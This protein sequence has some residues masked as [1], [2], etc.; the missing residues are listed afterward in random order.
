MSEL[1]KN[2]DYSI[3]YPT[4]YTEFLVNNDSD[5]IYDNFRS[6]DNNVFCE[7]S[8]YVKDFINKYGILLRYNYIKAKNFD[9]NFNLNFKYT[10]DI[11]NEHNEKLNVFESKYSEDNFIS[12]IRIYKDQYEC[13][14]GYTLFFEIKFHQFYICIYGDCITFSCDKF[15]FFSSIDFESEYNI[16]NLKYNNTIKFLEYFIQYI[17][18]QN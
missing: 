15:S 10:H 1:E 14:I 9:Y 6:V 4:K 11:I 12:I 16:E 5:I 17:F 7:Y 13:V 2:L 8:D 3:L 18:N